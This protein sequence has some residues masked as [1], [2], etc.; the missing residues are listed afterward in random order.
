MSQSVES[1]EILPLQK[2]CFGA[3]LSRKPIAMLDMLRIA[4]VSF[5]ILQ[6]AAN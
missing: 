3:S 5:R 2:R 1:P 4:E 6:T